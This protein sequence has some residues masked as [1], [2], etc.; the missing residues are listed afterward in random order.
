MSLPETYY[1]NALQQIEKIE[2]YTV[3]IVTDDIQNVEGKLEGI[4][5]KVIVSDSEIMDFNMLLHAD[6]LIISNSSFAWWGAYL[7]KKNA[8]VFVPQ[9]WLGFKIGKEIPADIIPARFIPVPVHYVINS[10]SDI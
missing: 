9:N 7:N 2:D 1:N 4:K 5:C 3:I 8:V 10:D 6:K